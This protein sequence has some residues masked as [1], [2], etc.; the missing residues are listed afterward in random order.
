MIGQGGK[1]WRGGGL[2]LNYPRRQQYRRLS[3]AAIAALASGASVLLALAVAGA[4]AVSR[5]RRHSRP[6]PGARATGSALLGIARWVIARRTRSG[7]HSRRSQSEG[8]ATAA[9]RSPG[10][11]GVP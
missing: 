2:G 8:A 9:L 6:R 3:R 5:V 7:V 1:T 10:F 11:E 4:G